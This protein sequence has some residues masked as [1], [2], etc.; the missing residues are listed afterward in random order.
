MKLSDEEKRELISKMPMS[1]LIMRRKLIRF[2][3][4]TCKNEG[5][6]HNQVPNYEKQRK[7]IQ[8]EINKRKDAKPVTI[9][10]KLGTFKVKKS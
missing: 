10:A 4:Q 5:D 1:E 7:R 8:Q 2:A 3:I 6:P 9:H